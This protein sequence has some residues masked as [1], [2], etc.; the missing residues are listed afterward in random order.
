LDNVFKINSCAAILLAAGDSS[1]LGRPKQLL[2]YKGKTLLQNTL[3]AAISAQLNPIII[4]LGA[5]ATF[6]GKKIQEPNVHIVY[7]PNWREGIASSIRQAI[8]ELNKIS[9]EADA[10]I[11]M[12]CDQPHISSGLLDDLVS[13]QQQTGK[14]IAASYYNGIAGTPALFHKTIFPELLLLKGDKGAGKVLRQQMNNVT[15]V[16]FPLGSIDIDTTENY[17]KL[18]GDI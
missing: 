15:T 17:E 16:P 10:A 5:D 12:V 18:M 6:V 1:R 13:A 8:N 2:L 11:L 9:P 4:I 14:P 7:N 3:S